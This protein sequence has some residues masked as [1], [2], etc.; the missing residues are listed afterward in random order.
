MTQG[1]RHRRA[2]PG[3]HRPRPAA[4]LF[5][6]N[7]DRD[8]AWYLLGKRHPRLGGTWANIGGSLKHGQDPLAGAIREFHEEVGIDLTGI[9]DAEITEVVDCGTRL[10]PYTM[11]VVNTT[12]RFGDVELSWENVALCW[13]HQDE[14]DSLQL[15]EGFAR[16]WAFLS[17]AVDRPSSI[18]RRLE[19]DSTGP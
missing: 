1:S 13:W 17:P 4:G 18:R 10:V 7:T 12:E 6:R 16:A 9:P 2:A 14:V 11:F 19:G 3:P 5:L 8:G 15:H